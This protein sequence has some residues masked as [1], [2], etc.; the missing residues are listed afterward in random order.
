MRRPVNPA[1]LLPGAILLMMP[2]SIK[3]DWPCR[4]VVVSLLERSVPFSMR[5]AVCM[6]WL[7]VSVLPGPSLRFV[8]APA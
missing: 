7:G 8:I 1:N 3:T 4:R 2:F 5:S 6:S